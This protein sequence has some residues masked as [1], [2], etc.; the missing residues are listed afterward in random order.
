MLL[1]VANSLPRLVVLALLKVN[2][3][4]KE[5]WARLQWTWTERGVGCKGG[6][7]RISQDHIIDTIAVSYWAVLSLYPGFTGLESRSSPTSPPS[8]LVYAT[9]CRPPLHLSPPFITSCHF[10]SLFILFF[11]HSSIFVIRFL[12]SPLMVPLISSPKIPISNE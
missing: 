7:G 6:R 3:R 10:F 8:P 4:E 2:Q 9:P 12:I 5:R 11:N 1:E